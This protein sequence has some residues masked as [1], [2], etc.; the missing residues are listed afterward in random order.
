[1]FATRSCQLR[2][3]R[4]LAVSLA[5]GIAEGMKVDILQ[6]NRTVSQPESLAL[7]PAKTPMGER[8]AAFALVAEEG[9]AQ[10]FNA[11]KGFLWK[12]EEKGKETYSQVEPGLQAAWKEYAPWRSSLQPLH[13]YY[14]IGAL[15]LVIVGLLWYTIPLKKAAKKERDP[16]DYVF[17]T[18]QLDASRNAKKPY[19]SGFAAGLEL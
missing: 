5:F 9:A 16:L 15:C 12:L 11:T 10:A 17:A 6:H 2:A 4:V 13:L 19:T 3:F 18:R 1:M 8:A 7:S 14:S